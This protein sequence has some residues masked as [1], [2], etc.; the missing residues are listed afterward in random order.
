MCNSALDEP[1]TLPPGEKLVSDL[2]L[3]GV[4]GD[5]IFAGWLL[6]GLFSDRIPGIKASMNPGYG[7]NIF[8]MV[9][10]MLILF[11]QLFRPLANE[12]FKTPYTRDGRRYVPGDAPEGYDPEDKDGPVY[13]RWFGSRERT[14]LNFMEIDPRNIRDTAILLLTVLF[15]LGVIPLPILAV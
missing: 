13:K 7:W 4:I 1:K 8:W 11:P 9:M 12:L 2:N 3:R 5:G 14:V 15:G 10:I 6:L